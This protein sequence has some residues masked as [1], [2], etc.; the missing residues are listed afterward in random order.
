MRL[1][2]LA[3]GLG[4][5]LGPTAPAQSRE[6]VIP[7]RIHYSH[8][9]PDR[10]VVPAGSTVRFVI[11]N[12]DPIAHEFVIGTVAQQLNHE[13]GPPHSHDGIP[14]Q[15]TLD[16]GERQDVVWTFPRGAPMLFACHRAGHYV[17]GMI[18]R[19]DVR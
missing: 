1:L 17:F 6:I 10:V 4:L 18:G 7:I 14:G 16:I 19:F 13:S 3:A 15:A 8:Y 2:G 9:F 12:E 11:T 5:I